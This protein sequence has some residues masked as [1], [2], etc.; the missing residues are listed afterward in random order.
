MVLYDFL[1]CYK[2]AAVQIQGMFNALSRPFT[3]FHQGYFWSDCCDTLLSSS[4]AVGEVGD[5]VSFIRWSC[6]PLGTFC[7]HLVYLYGEKSWASAW[8]PSKPRSLPL[9]LYFQRQRQM[10]ARWG[11][12]GSGT[13]A[14][15]T[16][17][18]WSPPESREI[19]GRNFLFKAQ[20]SNMCSAY[21]LSHVL[22]YD[23]PPTILTTNL[24]VGL[25]NCFTG[26]KTEAQRGG[27]WS[28][29]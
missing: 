18:C 21:T 2:W 3:S 12:P 16:V 11:I 19:P 7:F 25:L 14:A 17:W 8:L 24:Q 13:S 4:V 6:D 27:D 29:T 26:Q 5:H 15:R 20:G 28:V 9:E 10:K 22:G 1:C 23:S